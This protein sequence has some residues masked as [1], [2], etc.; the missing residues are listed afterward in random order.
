VK[1]RDVEIYKNRSDTIIVSNE[2]MEENIRFSEVIEV[3]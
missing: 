3:K 2:V 1:F